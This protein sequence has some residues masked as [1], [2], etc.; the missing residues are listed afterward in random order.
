MLRT[1]NLLF[2]L[3]MTPV[4]R[5]DYRCG[6]PAKT[7]YK[8]VLNS[9]DP[10]YGGL[11]ED[12]RPLKNIKA[13]EGECDGRPYYIPYDLPAYGCAVFRF[14]YPGAKPEKKKKSGKKKK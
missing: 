1:K 3:N 7:E 2:V 9:M 5:P 12:V 6:V 10:K 4:A 8:L 13:K 11:P 14:D